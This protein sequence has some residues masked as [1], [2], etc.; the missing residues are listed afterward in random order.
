M[1]HQRN[2]NILYQEKEFILRLQANE[3]TKQQHRLYSK[4]LAQVIKEEKTM[5]YNKKIQKSDNK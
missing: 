1:D 4:I 5:Y 2:K 3:A